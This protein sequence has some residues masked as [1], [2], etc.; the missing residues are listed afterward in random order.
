MRDVKI[1]FHFPHL[2][3]SHIH[4]TLTFLHLSH[5]HIYHI[6]RPSNSAQSST[7]IPVNDQR[8]AGNV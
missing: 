5:S 6:K 1:N 7:F 8:Y 4:H 3:H 2:S